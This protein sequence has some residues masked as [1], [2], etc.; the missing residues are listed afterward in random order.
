[1]IILN[2]N[3]EIAAAKDKTLPYNTYLV[4]YINDENKICYDIVMSNKQMEI[5]DYYWDNYRHG[6]KGWK[7]TNGRINPRLWGNKT[8][9]EKKK[10]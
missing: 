5:F 8:P 1:M 4:T 6:L 3:C 7:Q 2:P 9:D 10:K